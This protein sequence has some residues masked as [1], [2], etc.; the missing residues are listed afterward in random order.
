MEKNAATGSKVKRFSVKKALL[1]LIASLLAV[2]VIWAGSTLYSV[3]T[4]LDKMQDIEI[5]NTAIEWKPPSNIRAVSHKEQKDPWQQPFSVLLLGIDEREDDIGRSDT[6][7]L[8]TVNQQLQTIKMLSIPRDSRVE[9]VGNG[10]TEKIN[11][12]YARGGIPMA[13]ATVE[14]MLSV[15]ID[16]Y[17]TVN[18][19]GFTE[20]VNVLGG[21]EVHND[22][23][24][25]IGASKFPTGD[26]ALDGEKALIYSRIRYEDPRGDFGR[27][28]RQR[29]IIQAVMAKAAKPKILLHLSDIIDILGNNVRMNFKASDLL[30]LQKLYGKLDKEIEQIQFEAG[31]GQTID[32]IWYYVL[33]KQEVSKISGELLRHLNLN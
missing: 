17:V 11:Q 29:Q 10:T 24:F 25:V 18:M 23:E 12:A 15:P 28:L 21:V 8:L 19:E 2:I 7:L 31:H 27:Q 13:I 26:I 4:A 22:M 3:K 1:L 20:I 32:G 9:I 16:Y 6:M 14:K 30:E 5:H 33:D